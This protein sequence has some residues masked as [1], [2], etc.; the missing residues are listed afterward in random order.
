MKLNCISIA[1]VDFGFGVSVG[2]FNI[3]FFRI[4]SPWY[5]A[6]V[7]PTSCLTWACARA[8][9]FFFAE[10]LSCQKQQQKLPNEFSSSAFSQYYYS[11]GVKMQSFF[12]V[13]NSFSIFFSHS[14]FCFL[15]Q[16]RN[17]PFIYWNCWR[18]ENLH[19]V[20]LC[21][22][23]VRSLLSILYIH[24]IGLNINK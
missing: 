16:P 14:W 24:S 11:M 21:F 8:F 2:V 15:L 6:N 1:Q 18:L 10:D 13:N 17:Q 12:S 5:F 4:Y 22:Y 23:Y 20:M 3:L 7:R 9:L 19:M